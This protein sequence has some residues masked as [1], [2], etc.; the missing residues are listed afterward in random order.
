M[1]DEKTRRKPGPKPKGWDAM[2]GAE[3]TRRY[4][5]RKKAQQRQAE[6]EAT[7]R[8]QF[9]QVKDKYGLT[10]ERRV[11]QAIMA[12]KSLITGAH[13]ASV[14]WQFKHREGGDKDGGLGYARQVERET[15]RAVRCLKELADL[16]PLSDEQMSSVDWSY[17]E[18][19]ASR[20]KRWS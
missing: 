3:R 13:L 18:Q 10:E 2:S 12:V 5:Q 14:Q 4:R 15:V 8:F 20:A 9:G 6:A 1:S 16:L 19:S 11:M 7:P 17:P